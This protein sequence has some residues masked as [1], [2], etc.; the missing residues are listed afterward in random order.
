M[1]IFDANKDWEGVAPRC[2]SAQP[3]A[4]SLSHP[5]NSMFMQK[6]RRVWEERG[7]GRPTAA[8][9]Q[10]RN[11]FNYTLLLGRRCHDKAPVGCKTVFAICFAAANIFAIS[12]SFWTEEN[13]SCYNW[14]VNVKE[15]LRKETWKQKAFIAWPFDVGYFWRVNTKIVNK[16]S[17]RRVWEGEGKYWS[18]GG[19]ACL[20][21]VIVI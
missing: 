16:E 9:Q 7:G 18:I 19:L 13:Q 21:V 2:S 5:A 3:T 1:T 6:K 20:H 15:P 4:P 10:K 17:H 11:L 12:Q 14:L 8:S